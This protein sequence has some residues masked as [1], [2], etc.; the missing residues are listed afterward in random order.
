MIRRLRHGVIDLTPLRS[1]APFRRLWVGTAF[2]SLGQQITV[3]AVLYQ[4]WQLTHSAFW[5]GVIGLVNAVPM[6]V[7][8]LLGGSLADAVDRRTL[9]RWTTVGQVVAVLALAG[10]ALAGL[11]NLALLFTLVAA[12]TTA[13]ALGAPARRTFPARLLPRHKVAAGIALQVI[14][15][16]VAMLTGPALAGLVLG[17]W[18]LTA[19][20]LVDAAALLVALYGVLGLPA[21]PVAERLSRG[22]VRDIV[23]G[24]RLIRRRPA[25]QGSFLTDLLATVLAMP[26]ALFPAV[27]EIRFGGDPETLGLFLSAV[28]VGGVTASLASGLVTRADRLGAVQLGAAALWGV[29]IAGFGL[30]E[31]LWLALAG[32]VVAGAADSVAVTTRAAMVQLAT[33]D[34]HRGRVSSVEHV[35]GVAG[36]D[37]GNFR[38]G[39]VAS[40]TSA[41]FA[42]ASGGLL[43]AAAVLLVA[44]TNRPLRAFRVSD[45][46]REAVPAG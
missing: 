12:Q 45:P 39:L 21:M 36:P 41:P 10:Q 34:S 43:C 33:P 16:Q 11:D 25:V 14:T 46:E 9:V 20:Y 19:A 7:F 31:P 3:V 22:G 42:L 8:G 32:L 37:L 23:E 6:I 4:V 38:G 28:A 13:A 17:R 15:F 35:I 18:G 29:G 24:L 26:V 44:A 30:A 27:N 40:W 2:A 5:T 1:S